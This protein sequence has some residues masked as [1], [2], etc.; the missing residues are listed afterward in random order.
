MITRKNSTNNAVG[1][2][3]VYAMQI[4]IKVFLRIDFFLN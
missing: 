3:E 1:E 2:G 4:T